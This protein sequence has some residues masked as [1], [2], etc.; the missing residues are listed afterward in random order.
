MS[1]AERFWSKVDKT[2]DCW[3]WTAATNRRGYGQFLSATRRGAGVPG[4]SSGPEES[5]QGAGD[6]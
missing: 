6:Q 2:D 4:V 3:L 1:V 5:I